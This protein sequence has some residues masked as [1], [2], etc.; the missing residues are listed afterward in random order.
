MKIVGNW[1][2]CQRVVVQN[3]HSSTRSSWRGNDFS[4]HDSF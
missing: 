4:G 2:S 1:L 3:V